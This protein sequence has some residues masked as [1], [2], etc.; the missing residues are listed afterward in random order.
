MAPHEPFGQ[1]VLGIGERAIYLHDAAVGVQPQ[2]AALAFQILEA[3]GVDHDRPTAHVERERAGRRLRGDIGTRALARLRV[4]TT[5][6]TLAREVLQ[7][8]FQSVVKSA[9][10]D[11]LHQEVHVLRLIDGRAVLDV[12]SCVDDLGFRACREQVAHHGDAVCGI[13]AQVDV[14]DEDVDR[15]A[16]RDE[17]LELGARS[18]L[19]HDQPF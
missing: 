6:R 17:G 11:R 13:G 1:H 7:R 4:L 8:L 19:V 9:L 18:H 12:A 14:G 2:L 15:V 3:V 16:L 5:L 10:P